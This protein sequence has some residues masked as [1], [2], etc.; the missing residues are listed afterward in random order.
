MTF[1]VG[2]IRIYIWHWHER[3][4]CKNL[5]PTNQWI[6]LLNGVAIY[7]LA[8]HQSII[9]PI[10]SSCRISAYIF[11]CAS[12]SLAATHHI[13]AKLKLCRTRIYKLCCID[14]GHPQGYP[15]IMTQWLSPQ[16]IFICESRRTR[17]KIIR[18]KKHRRFFSNFI[19]QAYLVVV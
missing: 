15:N 18:R 10:S 1:F 9:E 8:R 6:Q 7:I 5:G 4:L 12:M 14:C 16:L 2:G 3:S 19:F 11:G 17:T 13:I